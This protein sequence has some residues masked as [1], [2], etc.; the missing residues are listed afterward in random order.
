MY[1]YLT[2]LCYSNFLF[3][4]IHLLSYDGSFVDQ[5]SHKLRRE[6]TW[7]SKRLIDF[8]TDIRKVKGWV[9]NVPLAELICHVV[10][11]AHI[12]SYKNTILMK[13]SDVLVWWQMQ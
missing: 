11:N 6:C 13:L 4:L 3:T 12:L 10:I 7:L 2:N 5:Y 8:K 1:M 9:C